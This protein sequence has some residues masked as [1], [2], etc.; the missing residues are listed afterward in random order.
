MAAAPEQ[1]RAR[2]RQ[3]PD[4]IH[5][6]PQEKTG[7]QSQVAGRKRA[8]S[9]SQ[10]MLTH[11]LTTARASPQSLLTPSAAWRSP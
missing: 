5:V 9:L 7:K 2:V 11:G 10:R 3:G 1:L 4:Q 6:S 8:A